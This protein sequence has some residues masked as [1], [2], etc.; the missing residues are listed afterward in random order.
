MK[1]TKFF[2]S[3]KIFWI[4][5]LV[6][7]DDHHLM[8]APCLFLFFFVENFQNPNHY[9]PLSLIFS[10]IFFYSFQARVFIFRVQMREDNFHS[11]NN[12]KCIFNQCFN[13]ILLQKSNV[14]KFLHCFARASNFVIRFIFTSS[15][16]F[17]VNGNNDD[18]DE[19]I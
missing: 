1:I 3:M 7:G 2:F 15:L 16:F 14:C 10:K 18:N 12:K 4:K 9:W 19:H 11:K 13:C 5:I 17:L 8:A 6:S